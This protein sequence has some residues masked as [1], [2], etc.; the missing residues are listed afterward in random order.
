MSHSCKAL[1]FRCMDFRLTL[2]KISALLDKIGYPEGSYDLVS[3]AGAAK[4]L[5]SDAADD[6]KFLLKQIELSQKLHCISEIVILYHD[7]CGAYGISDPKAECD[8]QTK[9]LEKLSQ[10]IKEKFSLPTTAYIVEGTA[11]G[12]LSTKKIS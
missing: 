12:N 8:V 11:S 2:S 6:K 10:M 5:L 3:A 4:D 9:D 1:I 7:N